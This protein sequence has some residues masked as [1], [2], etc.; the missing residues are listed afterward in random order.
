MS[1]LPR[2]ALF[3]ISPFYVP[4][5]RRRAEA[6]VA[7]LGKEYGIGA[8]RL[9]PVDVSFAAPFDSNESEPSRAKNRQVE[10]VKI[11]EK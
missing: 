5:S 3:E 10:L 1:S 8:Q 6:V 2:H 7:T 4:L 9:F 11:V